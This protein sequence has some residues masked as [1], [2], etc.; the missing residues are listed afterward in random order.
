MNP[1]LSIFAALVLAS[2]AGTATAGPLDTIDSATITGNG[3]N[4]VIN[5]EASGAFDVNEVKVGDKVLKEGVDYT[6]AQNDSSSPTITLVNA[7]GF[8]ETVTV[9]GEGD[10]SDPELE[11]EWGDRTNKDEVARAA[12][13]WLLG[14]LF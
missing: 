3:S 8:G 9:T 14:L 13:M 10:N 4:K 6:V 11:L 5:A 1:K 2:I 12:L 7:P